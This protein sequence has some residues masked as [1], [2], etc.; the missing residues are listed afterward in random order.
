MA[1]ET[2]T[3][4]QTA[5]NGS[6]PNT[7]EQLLELGRDNGYKLDWM[8]TREALGDSIEVDAERGGLLL[9]EIDRNEA[10]ETSDWSNNMT[11]RP[12]GAIERPAAPRIGNY[13]IRTK[14]DVW[15]KNGAQLYE[16]AVQRQWSSSVDIPWE[17]I[18]E[19][20]DEIERAQCQLGTFLT[21]VEFVAGDVPGKWI[22][23]TTPEYYEP[24]MFLI[25]QIMD[26]ARHMDVFRKRV[27]AN[28]G[29]LMGQTTNVALSG[30]AIDSARDFTEMSARL[31][32]SGE[33]L[34]LSIFRMGEL[35]SYNDAEK[36]IYRLAASDESRHVAFGVMH[37]Q[38]LAQTDPS[39]AEEIHSYLDEIEM[40]LVIGAGG[41]NPATRG[42]ASNSALSILL[43][44]GADAASMREGENIAL[45]VRQRQVKEYVQRIRVA[46]FGDRFENGRANA[47]LTDYVNA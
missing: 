13:S 5:T 11:G 21:E 36:S 14:S 31:H 29:G 45:A 41:Q 3:D 42:T 34:V 37:L 12:R 6:T 10:A 40:G 25:S 47:A 22:A 17:T 8:I 30:G 28:G 7:Y 44:G 4:Q 39:R 18:E 27:F 16:E 1:T 24:R 33:G 20:P 38:Y 26:E 32:I 23:E 46:G 43:G 2:R 9:Q 15:L 19:L 35:M